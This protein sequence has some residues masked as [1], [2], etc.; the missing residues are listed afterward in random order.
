[1]A[2]RV[3]ATQCYSAVASSNRAHINVQEGE[4]VRAGEPL[5][6]GPVDPHDIL[7]VRGEKELQALPGRARSELSQRSALPVRLALR[8][9]AE[10]ERFEL[11]WPDGLGT[12]AVCWA[13]RSPF[14]LRGPGPRCCPWI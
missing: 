1:V 14:P 7:R 2:S 3:S 8:K 4:R 11:S 12:L 6:D 10:R 9:M 5:M 13:P